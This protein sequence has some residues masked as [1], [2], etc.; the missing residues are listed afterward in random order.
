MATSA[1]GS[2]FLFSQELSTELNMPMQQDS[3]SQASFANITRNE[4]FPKRNAGILINFIEGT[5][6]QDYIRAVGA[7][8]GPRN[9]KH[10]ARVPSNRICIFLT[11]KELVENLVTA[12]NFLKIKDHSTEMRRLVAPEQKVVISNIWPD[13]PNH[14]IEN[15]LRHSGI[16]LL[17]PITH[18]KYNDIEDEYNHVCTFRRQVLI[19]A[20]DARLVPASALIEH[21]KR[22]N[23]IFFSTD[24][25]CFHCKEK[26]HIAKKCPKK[27]LITT[28]LQN[29]VP[30]VPTQSPQI[31]TKPKSP[32]VEETILRSQTYA[33]P[34]ILLPEIP[35]PNHKTLEENAI[36]TDSP[37]KI[38]PEET[39]DF[40]VVDRKRKGAT[41]TPS[42]SSLEETDTVKNSVN[43]E[44]TEDD[45]TLEKS[46]E[47]SQSEERTKNKQKVQKLK[48][49]KR[50]E[51]PECAT[52]IADLL[53]PVRNIID[54]NPRKY[55]LS[56][57][58]LVQFIEE[59][60]NSGEYL[61]TAEKYTVEIPS[62][63]LALQELR[64]HLCGQGKNRITRVINKLN[65]ELNTQLDKE[66]IETSQITPN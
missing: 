62:L 34:P 50:S 25:T 28:E 20:E 65:D 11:S 59:A 46:K 55:I 4:N 1:D 5:Q 64:K 37:Q 45:V 30:D 42:V 8:V 16:K 51:S 14:L 60:H 53:E 27:Q 13:V 38:I 17:S 39:T 33:E 35:I 3:F 66:Q 7:I 15:V 52:S 48:K 12:H 26:G 49:S 9:V 29:S 19:S 6:I 24:V 61:K 47:N 21:E 58:Q 54:L 40:T 36:S 56:S 23:Y 2:N 18:I 32:L 31:C 22:K 57:D 41:P 10:A 43:L 44:E 63:I